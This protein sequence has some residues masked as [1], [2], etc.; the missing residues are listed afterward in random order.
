MKKMILASV[1]VVALSM[2]AAHA[3]DDIVIIGA[4]TD[5]VLAAQGSLTGNIGNI[6]GDVEIANQ[7]V[8]VNIDVLSKQG[9][10]DVV[11]A[12]INTAP[13]VAIQL[14]ALGNVGNISGNLKKTNVAAGVNIGVELK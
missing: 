11:I 7:G 14:D 3:A 13:V 1:A 4:N 12:G 9:V 2:G 10:D 8:G 6:G 5:L